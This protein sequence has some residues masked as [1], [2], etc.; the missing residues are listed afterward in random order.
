MSA[1]NDITEESC[2]THRYGKWGGNPKGNAYNPKYCAEEIWGQGRGGLP[3]QCSHKPKDG[4]WCARHN[5]EKAKA[6]RAAAQA[7]YNATV[8]EQERQE[9]IGV[10]KE[11]ILTAAGA[12]YDKVSADSMTRSFP[13]GQGAVLVAVAALRALEAKA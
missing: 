9:A 3:A 11:A 1:F 10:A 13:D 7:A 8:L 6:Q 4:I 2:L 5:P 12:W